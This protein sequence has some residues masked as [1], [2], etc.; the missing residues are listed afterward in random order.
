MGFVHS[1][2]RTWFRY[3]PGKEVIS[4]VFKMTS[5]IRQSVI[6]KSKIVKFC[7]FIPDQEE[8]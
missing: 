8:Y 6:R 4:L 7:N 3:L 5:C 1:Q 2:L